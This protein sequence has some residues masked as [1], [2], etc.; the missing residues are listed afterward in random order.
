MDSREASSPTRR[1]TRAPG[2]VRTESSDA[3]ASPTASSTHRAPWLRSTAPTTPSTWAWGP[4]LAVGASSCAGSRAGS[5]GAA[6][7]AR[8]MGGGACSTKRSKT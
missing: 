6:T 3:S 5:A 7:E 8:A 2:P 4:V 1:S